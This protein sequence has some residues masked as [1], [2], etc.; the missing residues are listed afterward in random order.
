MFFLAIVD[1]LPIYNPSTRCHDLTFIDQNLTFAICLQ[2]A[3]NKQHPYN[4]HTSSSFCSINYPPNGHLIDLISLPNSLID[5]FL[6]NLIDLF[7]IKS[8]FIDLPEPNF[9]WVNSSKITNLTENKFWCPD[10]C[11]SKN[12]LGKFLILKLRCQFNNNNS[13]PCLTT[14]HTHWDRAPFI[15]LTN[16]ITKEKK[17]IPLASIRIPPSYSSKIVF[18]KKNFRIV[19]KNYLR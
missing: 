4:L 19:K 5:Q 3:T 15:C 13:K 10:Q 16:Q 6:Q 7:K 1:S 14:K 11:Q 18:L 8:S 17:Q 12:S 2:R 9:L